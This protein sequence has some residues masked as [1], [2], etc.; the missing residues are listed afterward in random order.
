MK[1]TVCGVLVLA[2]LACTK[3]E[4]APSEQAASPQAQDTVVA[5]V[6]GRR[7]TLKDVDERW[8]S[9]D[10]AERAR[11][12]QLL[13]QNRRNVLDQIVGDLL[14]EEAAKAAGNAKDE[15]QK[16]EIAARLKPVTDDEVKQFYEQNKD[17]AQGRPLAELS[18]MIQQFLVSQRQQQARAQLVDDL[19]KKSTARILLDPPRQ[20]INVSSDDPSSGPAN[21]PITLVEFSD[22]Q[23][24]YCARVVPT[25]SKLRAT[26]GDK[27]RVVFKDYPLAIHPEAPKAAEAAHCAGEQGKYWDMHDRM[28]ANQRALAV[29]ALKETAAGLGLDAAKFGQCLDSGKYAAAIADDMKQGEALGVQSTP[30]VY[31]NGRPILGAQPFE[32]FQSV[33]DE[34]LAKK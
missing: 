20:T 29:P 13:Y 7:I 16:K 32:F 19:K 8:Q 25:I 23:C 26:Y 3:A 21:A 14:I 2:A 11:V 31:I 5:E 34:E 15:Y 10:P 24:P 6:A 1:F 28:F 4:T 27:I 9:D 33:I 22:Y 18:P 12:T 30:T 17:R